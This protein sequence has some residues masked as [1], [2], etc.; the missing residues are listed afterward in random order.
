MKEE[1]KVVS[2]HC[3]IITLLV[4][5]TFTFSNDSKECCWLSVELR[6]LHC[7]IHA[8]RWPISLHKCLNCKHTFIEIVCNLFTSSC[9]IESLL[10]GHDHFMNLI[11]FL[12]VTEL[13]NNYSFSL[14]H[15]LLEQLPKVWC[16]DMNLRVLSMKHYSS[17]S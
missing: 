4:E 8:L 12:K 16:S 1:N 15:M 5:H 3:S 2:I 10:I 9:F 13:L 7:H 14:Y 6:W 11:L 17:L